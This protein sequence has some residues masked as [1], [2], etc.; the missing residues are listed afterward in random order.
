MQ[1]VIKGIT[2]DTDKAKVLASKSLKEIRDV[3]LY[4]RDDNVGGFFL[5]SLPQREQSYCW[6][7]PLTRD[8]A[9]DWYKLLAAEKRIC[10]DCDRIFEGTV[11]PQCAGE[12]V[13]LL[14]KWLEQNRIKD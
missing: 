4:C 14:S 2:Y 12:S 9:K 5:A 6:L 3:T 11:C 13:W 7:E 10:L 1:K 8:E